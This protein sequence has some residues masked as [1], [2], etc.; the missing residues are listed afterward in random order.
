MSHKCKW[1]VQKQVIILCR[2]TK[3][4]QLSSLLVRPTKVKLQVLE[5]SPI[6][7]VLYILPRVVHPVDVQTHKMYVKMDATWHY[8]IVRRHCDRSKSSLLYLYHM[9]VDPQE[10]RKSQE[11]FCFQR[12]IVNASA[13]TRR[14][15][16]AGS[17]IHNSLSLQWDSVEKSFQGFREIMSTGTGCTSGSFCVPW[18]NLI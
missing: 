18:T 15:N 9:M 1:Y 4:I 6:S 7:D 11:N 5:W 14:K 16:W 2:P 3:V 10:W 12:E 17:S 13:C 8:L